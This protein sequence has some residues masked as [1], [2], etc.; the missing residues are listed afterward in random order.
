MD[1][2]KSFVILADT[3]CELTKEEYLKYD[4]IPLCL[5]LVFEGKEYKD[6]F[7]ESIDS[8]EVYSKLRAGAQ[9]STQQVDMQTYYNEFTNILEKGK[10]ILYV[11]FSSALSGTYNTACMV[12]KELGEKY[13]ERTIYVFDSR[14]AAGGHGLLVRYA[15]SLRDQGKNMQQIIDTLEQEKL[16]FCHWFFVDDL[17]FLHRGGRVS[18][19]AAVVGT[20]IGIKPILC[21]DNEGRLIPQD[22]VRGRNQ[23]LK[24]LA[25]K[26]I[27]LGTD[28]ENQVIAIS[29]GDC[30]EEAETLAGMIREKVKVKDILIKML[31][32]V[33]GSHSGPGTIALFFRGERR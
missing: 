26:M 21:V 3:V 29:H 10:D 27:D 14:S 17:N 11:C 33:I 31:T 19:T 7:G 4:L 8:K 20:F 24:Y 28:L 15:I 9:S 23:A 6:D 12:A 2:D 5:S 18:K 25:D 13:P 1:Q 30:I 16:T 32:P 22:K